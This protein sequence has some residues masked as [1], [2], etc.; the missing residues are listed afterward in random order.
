MPRK[1]GKEDRVFKIE[2]SQRK[3]L[4]TEQ[5]KKLENKDKILLDVKFSGE[6]GKPLLLTMKTEKG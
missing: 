5:I 4:L 3:L 6:I 2:S 1:I